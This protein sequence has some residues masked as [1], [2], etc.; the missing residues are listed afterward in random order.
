[1][2]R[3]VLVP[4]AG[5]WTWGVQGTSGPGWIVGHGRVQEQFVVE[6]QVEIRQC[7]LTESPIPSFLGRVMSTRHHV[8]CKQPPLQD[9]V[10]VQ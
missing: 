10:K 2:Q 9:G 8:T 3:G 6:L 7:T 4:C 1:M 5:L